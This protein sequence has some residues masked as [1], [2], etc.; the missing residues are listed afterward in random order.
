MN[1]T[2]TIQDLANW[3][4]SKEPMT[5]QKL[6]KL[7]YYAVAWGYTLLNRPIVTDCDF[8][9][10]IH[11]PVSGTLHT[12]SHDYGCRDIEQV[13]NPPHF[14]PDTEKLLNSVWDTYGQESGNALEAL[15]QTEKPWKEARAHLEKD[16]RGSVKIKPE[17]MK[18]FCKSIYIGDNT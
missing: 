16:E 18:S 15:S 7:C 2:T 5:H 8:E 13:Q 14:P 9:A 10:W 3:F 1:Q 11:G 6:Q 12:K 17:T 4:L